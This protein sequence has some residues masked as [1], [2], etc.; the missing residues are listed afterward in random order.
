MP[1][2]NFNRSQ[3]LRSIDQTFNI[4]KLSNNEP[5]V[6]FIWDL[7]SFCVHQALSYLGFNYN[8]IEFGLYYYEAKFINVLFF[9]SNWWFW[10]LFFFWKKNCWKNGFH[11]V[12]WCVF[13]TSS[14][15]KNEHL[16]FYSFGRYLRY[17]KSTFTFSYVSC[18]L[19]DVQGICDVR[20]NAFIKC[21][22]SSYN[23][24][25]FFSLSLIFRITINCLDQELEKYRQTQS[26][27]Y[28]PSF[29][30]LKIRLLSHR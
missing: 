26:K 17:W 23:L 11:I 19:C 7:H 9:F 12:S 10:K 16:L 15:L 8:G 1:T 25:V 5:P 13:G 30:F 6:R 21:S 14:R 27:E 2:W 20:S 22:F 28:K 29:N 3:E 18:L 4:L 24:D